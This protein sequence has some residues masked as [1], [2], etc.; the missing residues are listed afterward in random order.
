MKELI[1]DI[2]RLLA[3][4]SVEVEITRLCKNKNVCC[5]DQKETSDLMIRIISTAQSVTRGS[6]IAGLPTT[7]APRDGWLDSNGR[8]RA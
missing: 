2:Q 5:L 6:K 8:H 1:R 7:G 3:R 4:K